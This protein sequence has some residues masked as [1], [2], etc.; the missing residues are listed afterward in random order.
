[1]S[2]D[3]RIDVPYL[4]CRSR[5]V[6]VCLL[7]LSHNEINIFPHLDA[8]ISFPCSLF[9]FFD[10]RRQD[11]SEVINQDDD[12]SLFQVSTEIVLSWSDCQGLEGP[13]GLSWHSVK[14]S[15][16]PVIVSYVRGRNFTLV[17]CEQIIALL[18]QS[19]SWPTSVH[20]SIL[21][22]QLAINSLKCVPRSA[23]WNIYGPQ[24]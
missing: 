20:R 11:H 7:R 6:F 22:K 12:R 21:G 15:L 23:R 24:Q 14:V 4:A 13:F 1:M 18:R 3:K 19:C 10:K 5:W 17:S 8:R 16:R 2:H 9:A